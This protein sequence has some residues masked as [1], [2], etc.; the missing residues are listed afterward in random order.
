[1]AAIK[2][3]RL[4]QIVRR[5]LIVRRKQPAISCEVGNCL[6]RETRGPRHRPIGAKPLTKAIRFVFP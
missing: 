1:M 6:R 3:L 5:N 2:V 4:L